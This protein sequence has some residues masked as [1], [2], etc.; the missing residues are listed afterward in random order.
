MSNLLGATIISKDLYNI[1]ST[2]KVPL[3]KGIV[4]SESPEYFSDYYY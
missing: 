2:L 3:R 4:I 1:T